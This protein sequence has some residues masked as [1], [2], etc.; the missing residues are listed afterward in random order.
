[1]TVR[2][3][4]IYLL[5][6][7]SNSNLIK[8]GV[9]TRKP[10]TRLKEHNT[11]FDKPAGKVVHATG[12]EWVIKEYYPVEDV[13][14]AES[15]FWHRPP[16]TELTYML[17]N[18]LL[19]LNRNLITWDWVNEGLD[20]AKQV[21]IR[22][23]RSQPPIPKTKKKGVSDF[24]SKLQDSDLKPLRGYGNGVVRMPFECP[25]GH[26]FK[27]ASKSLARFPFCPMCHP[28]KFDA[29]T[30]RSVELYFSESD[31]WIYLTDL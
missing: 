7:P 3:G 10:E 9:T 26:I 13:Y 20:I 4:Y 27:L 8:V 17:D 1:M 30:V 25:K 6:H 28:D 15:V 31:E 22:I 14:N 29:Y 24:V 5:T 18:E 19:T 11:H 16:L 2:P 21:G 12:K 23:D